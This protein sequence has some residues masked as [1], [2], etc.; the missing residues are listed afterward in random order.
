MTPQKIDVR[1]LGHVMRA[2]RVAAGLTQVD[3]AKALGVS[4]PAITNIEAGRRDNIYL[5]HLV[6]CATRSGFDM[7]L[8]IRPNKSHYETKPTQARQQS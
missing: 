8:V 1:Q 2:M 3:I 7:M 4:R 5:H 6:R